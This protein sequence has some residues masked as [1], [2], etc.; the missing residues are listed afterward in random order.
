MATSA[1]RWRKITTWYQEWHGW[2]TL[3]PSHTKTLDATCIVL[4]EAA[5]IQMMKTF[6][7]YTQQLFI[8]YISSQLRNVSR[9]YLVL[10]TYKDD[11]L[12]GT[13]R[14]KCGKGVRK[15]VVG[16]AAVPENWQ[17]FL[18]ADSNKTDILSFLSKVLLQAFCKEDKEV[19]L[20]NGKGCSA[21]CYCRMSTPWPHAAMKKLVVVC[22]CTYH[23]LHSMATTR[24]S[25][26]LLI[27]M[28]WSWLCLP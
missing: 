1:P 5:C 17:Y 16:N 23:T 19:V 7:K 6:D 14:T 25:F 20:T 10:D 24:C 8:Q 26:A 9:V 4:D 3:S 2:R 21:S 22:Y 15:R 18:R 11:S 27:P 13:A 28:L 12:K